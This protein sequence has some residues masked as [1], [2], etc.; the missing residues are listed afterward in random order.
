MTALR[1]GQATPAAVAIIESVRRRVLNW[2]PQKCCE[3]S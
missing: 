1:M 2:P 3:K